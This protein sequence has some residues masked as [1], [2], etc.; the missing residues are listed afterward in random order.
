LTT[1]RYDGSC[2]SQAGRLD[3][4]S[5]G[6]RKPVKAKGD[7]QAQFHLD[8]MVLVVVKRGSWTVGAVA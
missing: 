7:H 6:Q 1:F 4:V 8:K 5:S 2:G 3:C